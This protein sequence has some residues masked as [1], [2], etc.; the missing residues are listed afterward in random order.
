MSN[1]VQDHHNTFLAGNGSKTGTAP[2][3]YTKISID[4]E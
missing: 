1:A 4:R 2:G 3:K